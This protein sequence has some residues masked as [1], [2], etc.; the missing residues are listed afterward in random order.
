MK[1]TTDAGN[2]L[3]PN[4]S[5]QPFAPPSE[6]RQHYAHSRFIVIPLHQ[7]THWS[8]GSATVQQAMAMGKAVITTR[9]PGLREYVKDGETGILVE[10]GDSKGLAA[11]IADLWHNPNKAQEMGQAARKWMEGEFSMEKWVERATAFLA[12]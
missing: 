9:L 6:L 4:V 5:I 8:A 1:S 7:T 2:Q 11:A 3:P 10:P 12:H